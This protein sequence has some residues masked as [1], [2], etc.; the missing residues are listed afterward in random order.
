MELGWEEDNLTFFDSFEFGWEEA[1][2]ITE[3]EITNT[4]MNTNT[5]I[6]AMNS[7]NEGWGNVTV[8]SNLTAQNTSDPSNWRVNYSD[9][10]NRGY[11][12][13]HVGVE[14]PESGNYTFVKGTNGTPWWETHAPTAFP[15]QTR[16]VC[17]CH[18]MCAQ[19]IFFMLV[20]NFR[21]HS[22]RNYV[23][24]RTSFFHAGFLLQSASHG[25]NR[26][27]RSG[28]H[29]RPVHFGLS[30]GRSQEA[31]QERE[32]DGA[33][34]GPG[35]VPDGAGGGELHRRRGR[36]GREGSEGCEDADAAASADS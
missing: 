27:H 11:Q 22:I 34:G 28:G 16:E 31:L 26:R 8:P 15:S 21:I 1:L 30:G 2:T 9:Y 20:K 10:M 24:I 5:T 3:E 35:E 14:N 12:P 17:I 6:P 25:G 4:I 23:F 18:N 29:H 13:W 33:G 36:E 19:N 7:S 32:K